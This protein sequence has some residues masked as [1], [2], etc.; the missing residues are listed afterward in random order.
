MGRASVIRSQ[1]HHAGTAV[2]GIPDVPIVPSL[3]GF[4]TLINV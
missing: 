2:H 4:Y 1:A 3:P